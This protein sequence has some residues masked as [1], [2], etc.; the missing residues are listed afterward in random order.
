MGLSLYGGQRRDTDRDGG[1]RS[2]V[3]HVPAVK[4]RSLKYRP[5]L[6]ARPK[7]AS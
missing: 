5:A 6:Y 4:L 3:S 2:K 7:D 1:S